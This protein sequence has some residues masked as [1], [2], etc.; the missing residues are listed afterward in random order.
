VEETITRLE[1]VIEQD[2]KA[3]VKASV[4]GHGESIRELSVSIHELRGKIDI[5]F[6]ELETLTDE[7]G[8]KS[9]EFEERFE[10]L[11]TEGG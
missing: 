3:L 11:K 8:V 10:A 1:Q 6:D 2:T 7:L 9:R 5:L 4:K